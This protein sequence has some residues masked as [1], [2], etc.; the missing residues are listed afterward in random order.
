MYAPTRPSTFRRTSENTR[1][2]EAQ[3]AHEARRLAKLQAAEPQGFDWE[4][5]CLERE[6]LA[7]GLGVRDSGLVVRSNITDES[8]F[9]L[10][11]VVFP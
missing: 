6:R 11:G 8:R 9:D 4:D 5:D 2:V 3:A 10:E 7:C 1:E